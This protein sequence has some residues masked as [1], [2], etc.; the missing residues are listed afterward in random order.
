M[1]ITR[2]YIPDPPP[3]EHAQA[4]PTREGSNLPADEPL[5][6]ARS[7]LEGCSTP[8][9]AER[10]GLNERTVRRHAAREG[11]GEM[12]RLRLAEN[13]RRRAA[14]LADQLPTAEEAHADHSDLET[15]TDAHA[16]EVG[17]LLMR[18]EP[19]RLSRFAFRRA[20]EMAAQGRPAEA[21]AW[22][23][24]VTQS[25]RMVEHLMWRN[26]SISLADFIRAGYAEDAL[27]L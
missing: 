19:E 22:M 24:L 20:A 27:D 8:V 2:T 4:P 18:P 11:R 25:E 3:S 5:W 21:Q 10:H 14:F 15:F 13:E 16:F 9:V 6:A 17:Q 26:A 1:T 12:R 23:G 7:Y